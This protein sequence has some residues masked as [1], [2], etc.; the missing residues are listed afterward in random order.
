MSSPKPSASAAP[1][2]REN[3]EGV[4]RRPGETPAKEQYPQPEALSPM[5]RSSPV[6]EGKKRKRRTKV[7]RKK[8]KRSKRPKRAS[9][10]KR[11]RKTRRS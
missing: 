10:K 9:Q 2:A 4:S 7:A 1:S 11:G 5:D 8:S 3:T 6:A